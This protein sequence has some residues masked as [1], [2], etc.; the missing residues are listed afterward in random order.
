MPNWCENQLVI[1]ADSKNK[2]AIKDMKRL[3]SLLDKTLQYYD[4]GN[5]H[6]LLGSIISMPEVLKDTTRGK[7]YKLPSGDTVW[8]YEWCSDN[9]G[10]KWDVDCDLTIINKYRMEFEFNSAWAPP[11]PWL[12]IV[13]RL[14]PNLFLC[15]T[16][17]EPGACFR[18]CACGT[19][20]I[21]D[22]YEEYE[23]ESE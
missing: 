8:W 22:K 7:P 6:G 13:G 15:L 3:K 11:I 14:F 1:K 16:Y 10:T 12:E 21:I 5:A 19:G 18:G 4:D 9:W 2:E 23:H 17:D 20:E